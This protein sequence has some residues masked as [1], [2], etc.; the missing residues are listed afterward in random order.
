MFYIVS[1]VSP[2]RVYAQEAQ[3]PANTEDCTEEKLRDVGVAI[4]NCRGDVAECS[5]GTTLSGTD[6]PSKVWNFLIGK[7][8]TNIQA[9]GS[10]GNLQH[11]GNFNPKIVEGGG[12]SGGSWVYSVPR[13]FPP[14]S[15]TIPP[16]VGPAGQPGYGI[17]QWTSPGRK[18]GLQALADQTGRPVYDLQLQLEYMW[19]ELSTS[20]KTAA[21]DPLMAATD[22]ET[23][24]RIWQEKYEVGSGF[25]PRINAAREWL[26]RYGSGSPPAQT[27][28]TGDSPTQGPAG[29]YI[30]GDSITHGATPKYNE[31]FT[32]PAISAVTGRSWNSPGLSMAGATGTQ[33]T[34]KAALAAD[35]AKIEAATSIV[36]ALGTNGGLAENPVDEIISSVRR[37]NATAPI[38]W[39]NIAAT[40]D[41]VKPLVV[42]FNQKLAEKEAASQ[43]TVI[44]WAKQVDPS[45]D[46]TTDSTESLEDGVHPKSEKYSV[47]VGLV[48]SKLS[49]A[50]ASAGSC[51][52]ALG[53]VVGDT[54]YPLAMDKSRVI[55]SLGSCYEE[56][57]K[58][59]CHAGHPYLAHDLFADQGTQV[60]AYA[61]GEVISAKNGTCGHGTGSAFSVQVYDSEADT[62]YFY[63][64]MDAA[65]GGVSEGQQV[66]PGDPIG[67]VGN[68]GAACDTPPHL[69]FDAAKG[70]GRPPCSRLSCPTENKAKFQDISSQ[71]FLTVGAL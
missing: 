40:T 33:G 48:A 53:G 5:V 63:Q 54:R 42:P 1:M 23:A 10:M 50:T 55:S 25:E 28:G 20:Y 16:T 64:H 14:E 31:L 12:M 41:P 32:E 47:L 65:V 44:D 4:I 43:L 67:K 6:N 13:Q 62:T 24:T 37:I 56:G 3:Q 68:T 51:G 27:T 11:E 34:G 18:N 35:S 59:V 69:H 66:K 57:A 8:F 30:L 29:V 15:D 71:L 39:V 19:Q 70:R 46:G 45:G 61:K 17:V 21:L 58:K 2:L 7:S 9:A 52:D 60:V 22:L 36:I 49:G 26:D 38:Y